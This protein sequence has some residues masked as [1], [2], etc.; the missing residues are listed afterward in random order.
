MCSYGLFF[1]MAAVS[2]DGAFMTIDVPTLA[3]RMV[4]HRRVPLR[5]QHKTLLVNQADSL[6]HELRET[7]SDVH[8]GHPNTNG[9]HRTGSRRVCSR[10]EMGPPGYVRIM[11]LDQIRSHR[12]ASLHI[13]SFP[14]VHVGSREIL[15]R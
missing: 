3:W 7:R 2:G 14:S 1:G 12:V 9:G 5:R 8:C 11:C 6:E 4:R 13:V 15:V 10:E